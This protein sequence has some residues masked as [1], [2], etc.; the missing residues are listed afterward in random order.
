MSTNNKPQT[1]KDF[2]N[3]VEKEIKSITNQLAPNCL[4]IKSV[5]EWI[6][7]A[8]LRPIPRMLFSELWYENE[9]CI[10][11]SDSNL[12]KSILAIQIGNSISKGMYIVGF[13][14]ET[15]EQKVLYFDF[16]L[17]DK[18]LEKRYS[19]NYKD[20]YVFN[21]NFLRA[22]I[23]TGQETPEKFKSFEDFLSHSIENKIVD[24][25]IKVLIIDNITYLR[26]ETEKSK[27][28]LTLMKM[29]NDFKKKYGLSILVLA[30]TPK[31][32]KSK[33]LS[34]NDLSGSRMLMNFC[35]SA[36]A[37]G[38]DATEVSQRYIKQ[39][40]QRNTEQI[41]NENNV[42][43]C[44]IEKNENFLKFVFIGYGNEF[45]HLTPKTNGETI[46]RNQK[47]IELNKQGLSNCEIGRQLNISEGTVRYI[48]NKQ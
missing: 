4:N 14:L 33:P 40:K 31:R 7:E 22:E 32:D 9:L 42:I 18:Q 10:L 11:F 37:I 27:D 15:E 6:D 45:E 12:G 19:N 28:A 16:E 46:E 34:K 24:S 38:E 1:I 13:K 43:F 39:I 21:D 29:L 25:D 23:N 20:H 48:L 41:Y 17:T 2:K 3:E 36:F 35:D 5:K 30:H 47:I 8:K 44:K 26:N